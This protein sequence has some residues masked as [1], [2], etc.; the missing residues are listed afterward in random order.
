MIT[1]TSEIKDLIQEYNRTYN[2]NNEWSGGPVNIEFINYFYEKYGV[3]DRKDWKPTISLII[4][5]KDFSRFSIGYSIINRL[6]VV[7]GSWN[8]EMGEDIPDQD[9]L[10]AED[11]FWFMDTFYSNK[12]SLDE[13]IDSLSLNVTNK[14]EWEWK[15]K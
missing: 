1:D 14:I 7:S 10:K 5:I 8:Y 4:D 6:P 11:I 13:T 9:S 3:G 15:E 2:K 12:I